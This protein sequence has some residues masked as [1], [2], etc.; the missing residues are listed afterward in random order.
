MHSS[1]LCIFCNVQTKV[2]W[3][4]LD[5]DLPTWKGLAG[6]FVASGFDLDFTLASLCLSGRGVGFWLGWRFIAALNDRAVLFGSPGNLL[7]MYYIPQSFMGGD[8]VSKALFF[9]WRHPVGELHKPHQ[10][11][12]LLVVGFLRHASSFVAPPLVGGSCF[13]NV[14]WHAGA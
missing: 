7:N 11:G 3:V 12:K 10:L 14:H 8:G 13:T 9:L 4:I 5:S 1:F 6:G 2:I